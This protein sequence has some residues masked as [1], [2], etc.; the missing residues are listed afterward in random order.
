M[1]ESLTSSAGSQGPKGVCEG[2]L[3]GRFTLSTTTGGRLPGSVI[4]IATWGN[5]DMSVKE[6]TDRFCAWKCEE[7]TMKS[8]SVGSVADAKH[9]GVPGAA[10]IPP[11]VR[12]NG[13]AVSSAGDIFQSAMT[14]NGIPRMFKALA[15][16]SKR[17]RLASDSLGFSPVTR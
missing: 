1:L 13:A 7:Y 14:M 6:P 8:I 9:V 3:L 12:K 15:T 11:M 16:A 2:N 10:M 5:G 4:H 17:I